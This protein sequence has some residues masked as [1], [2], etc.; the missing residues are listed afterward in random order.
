MSSIPPSKRGGSGSSAIR[1]FGALICTPSCMGVL[2]HLLDMAGSSI[3]C[4]R[5][6][7]DL[8]NWSSSLHSERLSLD[9]PMP[10][11][12]LAVL[13]LVPYRVLFFLADSYVVLCIRFSTAVNVEYL[14]DL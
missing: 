3:Q 14:S 11:L 4:R 13:D 2:D 12:L 9:H 5:M 8:R 10:A 1:L 6:I 7:F